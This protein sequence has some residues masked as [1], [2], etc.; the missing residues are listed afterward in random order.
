M[1]KG[2]YKSLIFKLENTEN[3]ENFLSSRNGLHKMNNN[4]YNFF[5]KISSLGT[6]S[7]LSQKS[8]RLLIFESWV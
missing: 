2:Q 6:P 7:W 3:W 1:K 5:I 4:K 8:M